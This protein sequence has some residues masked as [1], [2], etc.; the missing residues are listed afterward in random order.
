MRTDWSIFQEL[1]GSDPF[2]ASTGR[3][4]A[5]LDLVRDVPLSSGIR[6][7]HNTGEWLE[8]DMNEMRAAISDVA[9]ELGERALEEQDYELLIQAG[10]IGIQVSPRSEAH[11][12]HKLIGYAKQFDEKSFKRTVEEIY[13]QISA[14]EED[15]PDPETANVI[16]QYSQVLQRAKAS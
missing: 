14:L 8:K 15:G 11:R 10:V 7:D 6:A 2:N 9:Y 1:V 12:R 3:L 5:A 4:K 13:E 16:A